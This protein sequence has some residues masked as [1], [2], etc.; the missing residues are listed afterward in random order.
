MV[1]VKD[2]VEY[3]CKEEPVETVKLP[4]SKWVCP[5]HY[6]HVFYDDQDKSYECILTDQLLQMRNALIPK[7]LGQDLFKSGKKPPG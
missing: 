6:N 7:F 3:I 2:K 1:P 5:I 4:I